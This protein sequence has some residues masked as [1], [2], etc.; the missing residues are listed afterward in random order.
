MTQYS[1][2]GGTATS[3][4]GE[5]TASELKQTARQATQRVKDTAGEAM[6]DVRHSLSS[7]ASSLL[8]EQRTVACSKAEGFAD[9]LRQSA[10]SVR[11]RD[12]A[13]GRFMG[14]AA[15]QVRRRVEAVAV[16]DVRAMLCMRAVQEPAVPG[17]EEAG[18]VE[19]QVA[20]H[21]VGQVGI[22][23]TQRQARVRGQQDRVVAQR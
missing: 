5:T 22:P 20:D 8:N 13:L 12:P 9:A 21:R 2:A 19:A 4:P 23:G 10:A 18:R 6:N 1:S 15:D 17:D 11:E 14:G 7:Q 3:K 16:Q